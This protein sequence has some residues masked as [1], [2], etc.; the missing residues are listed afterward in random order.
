MGDFLKTQNSFSCGEVSPEFYATDNVNGVSRLENVDVL[1][2]GALKRRPGL[3]KIRNISDNSILIPFEINESE[4]YLLVVYQNYIDVFC[5]DEK[6]TAV[7][8]PWTADM[9]DKLQYVQKFNKIYFVHPDFQPMVLTT[10]ASGFDLDGFSFSEI[11]FMKFDD[12]IGITIS[13][14]NSDYNNRYA[15]FTTNQ[16]FWTDDC[17]G[18]KLYVNGNVWIIA[19]KQSA[20]KV[21]VHTN[22]DFSI[23][24]SPISDWYESAFSAKRG[25]PATVSFHQ[26]RLVFGGTK[27]APNNI[28]MS[29]VGDY[30]NFD[31]GEG[32]DDDAIYMTLLSSQHHQICNIVSS[33]KMQI[34]TSK[35]EWAVSSS[36]LTPTNINIRQHTSVGSITTRY[37]PP[38]KIE[39][40]TVFISASGKSIRELDLDA[41]GENYNAND[42]C[43]WSGHLMQSP[44][45]IA[46][47]QNNHQ[48]FVVMNDGYM[49]VLNKY[50]NTEISAWARYVTDGKFKYVSVF[51]NQTYVVVKRGNNSILEKFDYDCLNDSGSY[52]FSYTISAFPMIVNN[53]SPKKIRLRKISL[54]LLNTKTVFVNGYRMEI[55]NE[56]YA[57]GSNGFSGDLSMNLLGYQM[58]TIKPLWTLSS[59][60]QLPAT[61]LSVTTD[62]W[63]LI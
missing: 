63:F 47:N 33:D 36:P 26:N 10:D 14:S 31:V 17:V 43:S 9:L 51:N 38:Q 44:I 54:R 2:S 58:D 41:L 46:Y 30:N 8:S 15:Y 11:P 25:W 40:A 61:I 12:A 13:M 53:H 60:E 45:S 57:A 23:P 21:H 28:W 22:S 39:G 4:K 56:Y 18:E 52:D 35:G 34:L 5:N 50:S 55:D 3:R 37:L 16:S 20:T 29:R 62:G 24:G 32:L 27:S 48:L 1:H 42:L 7:A 59:S 6:L 49:A 19:E